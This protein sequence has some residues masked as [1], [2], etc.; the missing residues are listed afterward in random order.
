M[1]YFYIFI[2]TLILISCNEKKGYSYT[3]TKI[4]YSDIEDNIPFSECIKVIENGNHIATFQDPNVYN[5][6]WSRI[7]YD[8]YVYEIE[9]Y[10]YVMFC[11]YK[12]KYKK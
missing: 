9:T 12:R 11:N 7:I 4:P 10:E 3:W 2:L 6:V 1:R 8:G 5:H